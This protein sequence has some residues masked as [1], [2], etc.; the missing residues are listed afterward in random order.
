MTR[1]NFNESGNYGCFTICVTFYDFNT[2]FFNT[3]FLTQNSL[4]R[5]VLTQNFLTQ[6][7]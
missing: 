3:T 7:F 4:T 1:H 2:K 6:H 5:N